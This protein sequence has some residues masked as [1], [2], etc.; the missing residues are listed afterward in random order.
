MIKKIVIIFIKTLFA[1]FS[2]SSFAG[3]IETY[4]KTIE[5]ETDNKK[6][7]QDIILSQV[8]RELIIN[9]LGGKEYQKQRSKIEK[10]I[11]KNKNRYILSID[12]S[13]GYREETGKFSFI[14][15]IKVSK[16]NL[17][18]M[19]KRY[20]FLKNHRSSYCL[21]PLISFSSHFG[22]QKHTWS[23]WNLEKKESSNMFSYNKQLA[24]FFFDSL[25]KEFTKIG[26]YFIDPV[27]QRTAQAIPAFILPQKNKKMKHFKPIINFYSC[28]IILS[29]VIHTG[30]SMGGASF[31]SNDFYSKGISNKNH[32]LQFVIRGF[33]IKTKESLFELTRQFPL[34][35]ESVKQLQEEMNLKSKEMIESLI[36]RFSLYQEKGSLGLDRLMIAIQGNLSYPEKEKIITQIEQIDELKNIQIVYLSSQRAIYR[37][38]SSK[39]INE[40][41]KKIK[42]LSFNNFVVKIR[43]SGDSKLEIYVSRKKSR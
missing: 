3:S 27:F 22:K 12:S 33:N 1:I 39:K 2:L 8:S 11:I 34:E 20:S 7:A 42:A 17:K 36:Y 21:L 35:K 25:G 6:I 4:K 5:L 31:L 14:V 23:W 16:S 19:L 9:I 43:K 37:V 28:D 32:W 38:E 41:I 24:Q 15:N 29:G 10:H 26:F 18:S 30:K 13:S 40:I